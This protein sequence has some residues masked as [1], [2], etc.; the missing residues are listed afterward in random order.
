MIGGQGEIDDTADAGAGGE[1]RL[2]RAV[3]AGS[4]RSSV[5]L[6]GEEH[7]EVGLRC[8]D[9]LGL[10]RQPGKWRA[11]VQRVPARPSPN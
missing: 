2:E 4:G 5:G 7:R 10:E 6:D 11:D 8:G 1:R 3:G 9:D